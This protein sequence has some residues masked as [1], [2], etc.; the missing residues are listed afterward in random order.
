M[1]NE[2]LSYTHVDTPIGP[3]LIAGDADSLRAVRFAR[4]GLAARPES[5]W[6]P[7]AAPLVSAKR[8]ILEYFAGERTGFELPLRYRGAPFEEAVWAA[9]AAIPYGATVSYGDIAR[10]IGE[11]VGASRAVGI[12]AGANPLPIVIACHRVIGADGSLTGFGG[13]LAIKSRLLALER[14]VQPRPGQQLGLF[15]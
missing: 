13:G 14:R 1:M 8:Q 4:N 5:G 15:D 7:N 12:A 2:R 10:A 6:E 9:I 11:P 3:L